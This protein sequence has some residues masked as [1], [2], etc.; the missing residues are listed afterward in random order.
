MP[1]LWEILTKR[2]EEEI[3]AED[4]VYNPLKLRIAGSDDQS[5]I[6]VDTV[7]FVGLKFIV[8]EIRETQRELDGEQHTFVDYAIHARD[9]ED[10]QIERHLRLMPLEDPDGDLTHNCVLLERLDAFGWNEEFHAFINEVSDDEDVADFQIDDDKSQW[11]RI[12]DIK[13]AWEATTSRL[14]DIDHSGKIDEDEVKQGYLTYWDYWRQNEEGT[15]TEFLFIEM[16]D[17][18]YFE[19]WRGKE[20]DPNRIEVS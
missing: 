14:K 20:I 10:N 8:K 17:N 7:D 18:G 19:L 1:T 5:I 2:K 3:L 4:Q 15:D 13:T 6:T 12:N 9:L 11:W 16:D